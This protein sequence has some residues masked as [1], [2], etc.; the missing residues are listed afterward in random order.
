MEKGL[1]KL[2]SWLRCLVSFLFAGGIAALLCI[3]FEGPR[4]GSFYDFL[5]RL[6]SA[7]PVSQEIL[8]I[9]SVMPGQGLGNDILEPGAAASL[10]YTLTEL[11]A[12]TLIIQ[13]PILG[14]S[15]GGT[16]AEEEIL[17]HFDEEF[18]VL[19]RNIRNLFDGIRTGSVSPHNSARYVGELVELSE[20]G[21]ERLV[22]ALVRRDEEGIFNMER[23]AAFF[24]NARRPGDLRVQLIRAGTGGQPGVLEE[25]GTYSRVEPDR[26]GVLRRIAPLLTVPDLSEGAARD[27]IL[28]HIIY[29]TLKTRY[30]SSGI[31]FIETYD[32]ESRRSFHP[33][34]LYPM[35]LALRNGPEGTDTILPLDLNGALLFEAPRRGE[36]FRRICIS[37]FLT[38]D[39]A[40]RDL[41]RLVADGE[42]LG[43]FRGVDGE[44]RPG[45]LY[46]FALSLREEKDYRQFWIE[47][48]DMYFAR[49]DDFLTGPAEVS[50]LE[51]YEG[52]A[53][54]DSIIHIFEALREKYGEVITLRNELESALHSSFCILGN[55]TDT[56]AS[57]LLANSILVGRVVRP[58]ENFFLLLPS[59][60]WIFLTCFFIKTLTSAP[61]LGIGTLLSL[62]IGLCFSLGFILS[63]LWLN[64]LVPAA[65]S[66]AGMLVSYL[67]VAVKELRFTRRFR[68]AYGPFIS[69]PCL[70]NLIRAGQPLPSQTLTARAAVVA[71]KCS[72]PASTLDQNAEAILDFQKKAAS[73]L[74]KAGGTII[75]TEGNLVTV[76]FGSPLERV[77]LSEKLKTS[78]YENNITSPILW[79]ID[80][81]SNVATR[82]EC[83]SWQFGLDTGNCIFAWTSFS[84]YFALGAPVQR[85]RIL[86]RMAE[87]YKTQVIISAAVCE[88]LSDLPVKKLDSFKGK[89]GAAG[90][91]F[92]RL[93][94]NG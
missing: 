57:A 87:R 89:D 76:C 49:L 7:P 46:D 84:G 35:V 1:S 80:F 73:L 85:A 71:V 9:D 83:S 2:D 51:I 60:F 75:G 47:L 59:L 17:N 42:V 40:D 39:E 5:L 54:R 15:V 69:R 72:E 50:L 24:G 26:D 52:T 66:A 36:G 29:G 79:A 32:E 34:L 86:S 63:G 41:R 30:E 55:S 33:R 10:L 68:L 74:K 6:R 91:A 81:V 37:V 48:R 64:P 94:L 18:S 12:H 90:E 4:L 77:S 78:P 8:I 62:F 82:P 22:S 56:E 25:V 53:N 28:E 31:E 61:T 11:G 20:R 14:L 65:G 3:L 43:I 70:K 23:A 38:Y 27:K 44:N 19:S 45:F 16:A 93:V 13:V 58:G 92:F 88:N 67:W 21:K